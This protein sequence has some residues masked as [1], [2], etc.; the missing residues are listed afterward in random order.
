MRRIFVVLILLLMMVG[1]NALKVT[2]PQMGDPLTLAA[3]GFV[4]LAA[5]SISE[6]GAELTL[7]RVTGYILAGIIL[8]PYVTNILS[9]P[10]VAE[11][12]IFNTLALGLIALNAGLEFSLTSLKVIWKTLFSTIALKII[13]LL[14]FVGG[15]FLAIEM[16]WHYLPVTDINVLISLGLILSV[17]AIG[18]SPAIAVAVISENRAKGRMSDLVL[19]AAVVKDVVMVISLALALSIS[20]SL[21]SGEA[22]GFDFSVLR[23]VGTELFNSVLAGG[24]LGG[25][26]ILYLRYIRAE[27]LL[28]VAAIILA[29]AEI[30]AAFHLEL[31]LV[32]IVAGAVVRNLSPYEHDFLK[33]MEK[34]ALPVFV[35]FFTNAGAGLDLPRVWSLF[36]LAAGVFFARGFSF[37]I[38]ARWGALIGGEVPAIRKHAWLAYLPQAGV[39]VGL[40]GLAAGQV[41]EIG[42]LL[43]TV[44][45]GMVA[46]NLLVGPITLKGALKVA[47]DI[48]EPE[49][50]SEEGSESEAQS[51]LDSVQDIPRVSPEEESALLDSLTSEKLREIVSQVRTR[52]AERSQ[53]FVKEATGDTLAEIL[54]EATRYLEADADRK[55][56]FQNAITFIGNGFG[57]TIETAEKLS[58]LNNEFELILNNLPDEVSVPLEE[59]HLNPQ[60][61]DSHWKRI[62]KYWIRRSIQFFSDKTRHRAVPVQVAAKIAF[63]ES[64]VLFARNVHNQWYLLH[65]KILEV[66]RQVASGKEDRDSAQ[67]EVTRLVDEWEGEINQQFERAFLGSLSRFIYVLE[68]AGSIHLPVWKIRLSEIEP[69]VR[70]AKKELNADVAEWPPK[71]EAAKSTFRVSLLAEYI[72]SEAISIVSD[73]YYQPVEST[74]QSINEELGNVRLRLQKFRS[75]IADE[76]E[77]SIASLRKLGDDVKAWTEEYFSSKRRFQKTHINHYLLNREIAL[78]FN[79]VLP[80]DVEQFTIVSDET[81]AHEALRPRDIQ[82]LR[83]HLRGVFEQHLVSEVLPLVE[84]ELEELSA[85]LNASEGELRESVEVATYSLDSELGHESPRSPQEIHSNVIEGFDRAISKLTRYEETLTKRVT[86]SKAQLS[87]IF[88]QALERFRGSLVK[89]STVESAR[90]WV[91]T[92]IH[93]AVNKLR[94]EYFTVEPAVWKRFSTSWKSIRGLWKKSRKRTTGIRLPHGKLDAG[95]I[96]QFL[97]EQSAKSEGLPSV[98]QRLFSL[99]PLRDRRFFTVNRKILELIRSAEKDWSQGELISGV[100]VDGSPG[101]GRTSLL[102]VCQLEIIAEHVV[103]LDDSLIA[104]RRG[105]LSALG[106]ELG[107]SGSG[108]AIL[109]SLRRRKTVILIDNLDYWMRHD[110]DGLAEMREL[111][112]IMVTSMGCAFWVATIKTVNLEIFERL[113][114]VSSAFSHRAHLKRLNDKDI[115]RL[116]EARHR[117]SGMTLEFER[118]SAPSW[119]G[120]IGLLD[121]Q[122]VYFRLLAEASNGSLRH[123]LLLWTESLQRSPLDQNRLRPEVGKV[124][125]YSP[126]LIP[127]IPK[128]ALVILGELIRYGSADA[129]TLVERLRIRS[130]DFRQ[131]M[132]FLE[133]SGLVER[134]RTES[135]EYRVPLRNFQMV[136]RSLK[137]VGVL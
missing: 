43:T 73:K 64:L 81:P 55:G 111:F 114:S 109:N 135:D 113:F 49:S 40:V 23:S 7:P 3:I 117:V 85:L 71:L 95:S 53:N 50:V 16:T 38:A 94:I 97:Q 25:L 44:G 136:Y 99:E 98:Y 37:F 46:L 60:D 129:N 87:S 34:V 112:Q 62:Q 118:T 47:G 80:K 9:E 24:V 11:I 93:Q 5:F 125:F 4:L 116:V 130:I 18:T 120:K 52:I 90:S 8:G 115:Q 61:T 104:R 26:L 57:K 51:T 13:L 127:K 75:S 77:I 48:P 79:L 126:S 83:V 131:R 12:R 20:K 63:E 32:F 30:S 15:T 70:R 17:L 103:R 1:L 91:R 108:Q 69:K 123:S 76:T 22:G 119:L 134:T 39:T 101:M 67:R 137:S 6:L 74:T 21:L 78:M 86:D 42:D 35:V 96:R 92:L 59:K 54:S 72:E 88:H 68:N 121:P 110:P 124:S 102:N 45:L 89:V 29:V 105:V 132:Q 41:P 133:M 82:V 84:D 107:V 19:G 100:L 106:Q 36:P 28:F 56:H 2:D 65:S 33:P 128:P 66:L 31:L 14:C 58:G 10:V 122:S 27:M